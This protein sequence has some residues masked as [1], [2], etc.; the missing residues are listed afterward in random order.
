MELESL[1][2][3]NSSISTL[4]EKLHQQKVVSSKFNNKRFQ[5]SNYF[6][7]KHKEIEF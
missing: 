5:S 4:Q 6:I 3:I 1:Q 7:I 2:E